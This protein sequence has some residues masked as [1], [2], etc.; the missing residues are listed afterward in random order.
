MQKLDLKLYMKQNK[1]KPKEEI[2]KIL[3]PK[4]MFQRSAIPL[5]QEKAGNN[6]ESSLTKSRQIVFIPIKRNHYKSI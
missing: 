2:R 4:E 1:M 5:G 6:L 3:T